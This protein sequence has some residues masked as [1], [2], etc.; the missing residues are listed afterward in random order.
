M[1]RDI[2]DWSSLHVHD[3]MS[4]RLSLQMGYL[5]LFVCP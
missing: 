3:R 4:V 2:H 1:I 5:C